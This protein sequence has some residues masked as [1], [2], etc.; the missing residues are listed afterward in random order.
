[1]ATQTA[2]CS[3]ENLTALLATQAEVA[4]LAEVQ[5]ILN[6][7]AGTAAAAPSL[8]HG[9]FVRIKDGGEYHLLPASHL[10]LPADGGTPALAVQAPNT[11]AA[12]SAALLSVPL[13]AIS[14]T[15]PLLDAH[16]E[17]AGQQGLARLQAAMHQRGLALPLA[18]AAAAAWR[19]QAAL[20][21]HAQHGRQV[22]EEQHAHAPALLQQL[23]DTAGLAGMQ[24]LLQAESPAEHAVFSSGKGSLQVVAAFADAGTSAD[25]QAGG[26]AH[27]L[28]GGALPSAAAAAAA[29]APATA[30][31]G[32]PFLASPSP[33]E[34]CKQA[35]QSGSAVELGP[36][37]GASA[38]GA[39]VPRLP[40]GPEPRLT[41]VLVRPSRT[42]LGRRCDWE[43]TANGVFFCGLRSGISRQEARECGLPLVAGVGATGGVPGGWHIW[44]ACQG[45]ASGCGAAARHTATPA[46]CRCQVSVR[47]F[48]L[49][50]LAS[51]SACS[52]VQA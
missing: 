51:T 13:T 35:R 31:S 43:L 45:R 47:L 42:A 33:D 28:A 10:M 49:E 3:R 50:Q 17:A 23:H 26:H 34:A 20:R 12:G 16:W 6:A 29:A 24:Q 19:K 41:P 22:P 21:W 27:T 15:N 36:A 52:C 37:A 18:Q 39:A 25:G 38:A 4:R 40:G 7:A 5:A 14:G 30:A 46:G 11:A 9:L 32:P 2:R 8:A 1:M 48:G 44:C